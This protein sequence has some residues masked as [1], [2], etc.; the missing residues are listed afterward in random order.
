VQLLAV[1]LLVALLPTQVTALR[2]LYFDPA[3]ARDDYRGIAAQVAAEAGPHDGILLNAPNQWEVFTYYYK[4]SLAVYPAPYHPT[5]EEARSWVAEILQAQHPTLFAL[6]WG[7]NESDPDRLIERE[8]ARQA[9]KAGEVW[10][11]DIRVAIYGRGRQPDYPEIS[12]AAKLGEDIQLRGFAMPGHGFAPGDIVPVTLFWQASAV[13]GS[14]LKVF[15]HL[16]DASGQLR[17]QTDAEPVGGFR[18]T[19]TWQPGEM[20]VDRYGLRLPE[21]LPSGYY[22]VNVGMYDSAGTR[23]RVMQE[24]QPSGDT[25]S[26]GT[27]SVQ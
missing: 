27:V 10:I 19:T 26:L 4:G 15:V 22:S 2:N 13:P 24:G 6:Y 17:A 14:R 7:D 12:V 23:L 16:L 11:R 5:E 20:I 9:Y 3:Y 25:F 8:L 21:D 18:P 1:L